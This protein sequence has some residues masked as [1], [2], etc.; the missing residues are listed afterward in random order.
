M[1]GNSLVD[2]CPIYPDTGELLPVATLV[3]DNGR[4]FRSFRF[5][6]FI[7][8][9]PELHHIRTRVMS[10]G[11]DGSHECGFESVQY[12]RLYLHEITD[13]LDLDKHAEDDRGDYNTI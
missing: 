9:H 3:T 7:A 2:Q 6:A 4:P 13:V 11:Q 1:F 12:A 5:E 10:P 8:Q